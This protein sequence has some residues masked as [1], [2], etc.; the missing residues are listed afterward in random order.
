[1]SDTCVVAT[2]LVADDE[3]NLTE[4]F[5]MW[6]SAH[7][8]VRTAYDGEEA[9]ERMS[10]DVVVSFLDRQ[11]PKRSGGEVAAVIAEEYPD[12]RIVFVSGEPLTTLDTDVTFDAYLTKPIDR[13]DLLDV[14]EM[15]IPDGNKTS[16]STSDGR[17][18][19]Q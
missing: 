8:D 3:T 9:L 6:L 13:T 17:E 7:Y 16:S 11:M 12:T 2:V 10:E 4:L 19:Q 1:M 14:A 15:L 5:D 18:L